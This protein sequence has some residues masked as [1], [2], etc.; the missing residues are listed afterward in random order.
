MKRSPSGILPLTAY[1]LSFGYKC[2][3]FRRGVKDASRINKEEGWLSK[4]RK[5]IF[6]QGIF[7]PHL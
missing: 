7:F 6:L 3:W 5:N 4:Y 1:I 2:G